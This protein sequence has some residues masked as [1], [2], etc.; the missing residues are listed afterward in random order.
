MRKILWVY[1]LVLL[2]ACASQ[3]TNSDLEAEV[4]SIGVYGNAL[5]SGWQSWS[6]GTTVNLAANGGL[7]N[8]KALS[9]TITDAWAALFLHTDTLVD[10]SLVNMVQFYI[11]GG[12]SGGQN[13]RVKLV[14]QSGTFLEPGLVIPAPANTWTR[15]RIPIGELGA[16]S[17]ISGIIFQDNTGAGLSEFKLDNISFIKINTPVGPPPPTPSLNQVNAYFDSYESGFYSWSWGTRLNP[18]SF[19]KIHTGTASLAVTMTE[20]WAGAFLHS[21]S[22]VDASQVNRLRFWIHGGAGN[23]KLRVNL[24]DEGGVIL[25]PGQVITPVANTWT[26]VDLALSQLGSPESVSGVVWQDTSGAAQNT[27]YLDEISFYKKGTIP[28]VTALKLEVD[29]TLQRYAISED[30]YGLSWANESLASDLRL[31]FNRSGGNAVSRYNYKVNNTNRGSD[32]Y[33]ENATSPQENPT[34]FIAQNRRT[35]TKTLLTM[36]MTGWVTKGAG[37]ACGFLISKYGP[38]KELNPNH[39][40]CGNG[41]KPD[42][43]F[44]TGNDPTD[45]SIAANPAFVGGWV[46]ELVAQYGRASAGGVRYYSL[47][48]E[49]A[50]WNSTHRDIH[51][52][53]LSYDELLQRTIDYASA[54][55]LADSTA[56]TVGPAEWGWSNYFYSAKDVAIGGFNVANNHPDRLAHGDMELVAWYL[57]QLRKYEVTNAKRLLNYLDL[58]FYPQAPNV[59]LSDTVDPATKALRLR[60]TR[61]L[62]DPTYQDESWIGDTVKLIP[63]MRSW[64]STYYP[65]TKVAI[66]E[67]NWGGLKDINGALAQAD[68]LGIFGRER[69]DMA[70]L[71][72]MPDGNVPGVFAFRMY[73][74]YDGTGKGFGQTNLRAISQDQ[75]KVSLYAAERTDGAL[76]IIA[77]NKSDS[78]RAVDLTVK[79]FADSTAQVYRYSAANLNAIVK[80][81]NKTLSA[82]KLSTSLPG[83][84]ITLFVLPKP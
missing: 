64:I 13:L 73:R 51:P 28:P 59:T 46:R 12:S 40:E 72:E 29:T 31:P 23:Q 41:I 65:G 63:R 20:A 43:S 79:N 47:D 5:S 76:T 17:S 62:W 71:W 54:I 55:K 52:E 11:N 10:S 15:V 8:S 38:Q 77:I 48:N 69:V 30:I 27:F 24:A 9:A 84:S 21:D 6:W 4:F 22:Y 58:H 70:S 57:D 56:L 7:N 2:S 50:L 14:D 82:G 45:T 83:A 18:L 66:T 78:S 35:N 16:S 61:A 34:A 74:N 1:I 81:A 25:E 49:P 44:V 32:W 60:S 36:P 33:F 67:Y 3:S 26:L 75:S 53:P 19:A 37:F 68:V 42:G 39:P 80:E